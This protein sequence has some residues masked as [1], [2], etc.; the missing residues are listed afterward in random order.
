MILTYFPAISITLLM[1]SAYILSVLSQSLYENEQ[2]KLFAKANI[3]ADTLSSMTLDGSDA[4]EDIARI[5][6]G[7]TVRGIIVN[8]AYTVL[9]DTAQ[10]SDLEG[11][12]FTR[13]II[14]TA[15]S[16]VQANS[17]DTDTD[18]DSQTM[19]VCV[20]VKQGETITGATYL[21]SSVADIEHTLHYIRTSLLLFCIVISILVGL[22]SLGIS[23]IVTAPLDE[24][25]QTA[26]EISKGN[27]S[28][29][30]KVKGHNEMSQMAEMLNYM[31]GELETLDERR[32][33]F[34]SDASHELKTPLAT[35][36]LICDSLVTNE[37]PNVTVI[38]EFL[39][40]LSDEVDRLT[41]VIERLLALTKLDSGNTI[42]KF[43]S[44]DIVV[45]LNTIVRKLTAAANA[46]D[47]VLYAELDESH[48]QPLML[49]YD[50]IW[51]AIYNIVD[52]A[53]KY[54]PEGGFVRVA[55]QFE[56]EN[57]MIRIED[58]GPGIPA[59]ETERIFERF[60]RL[61]DSRARDTGGTGLGLAIAKEAII[62][63]GGEI[64]VE[65]SEGMGSVFIITLPYVHE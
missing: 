7:T 53:I 28:V 38:K 18:T 31:C 26:K 62:M 59:E 65:G 34:V 1:M 11:K 3:I 48:A 42:A 51:E 50:K 13:D 60:Y 9:I 47:I 36:K 54:S 20:P 57:V 27:F 41:R 22:L 6:A 56:P 61:D 2:V 4:E 21:T 43:E 19:S 23:Y 33:K 58:N 15:L 25:I 32:K 5:L 17:L 63:H 35:I 44:V 37:E 52:N 8:S 24:F 55:L 49:D 30:I 29:R 64:M 14:K 10:E 16:G 39:G 40:D 12:I 46:K 45:M